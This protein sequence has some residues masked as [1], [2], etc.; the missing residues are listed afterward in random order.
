MLRSPILAQW[1]DE[2]NK[3]APTLRCFEYKVCLT[4]CS[5]EV[6]LTTPTQGVHTLGNLTNAKLIKSYDVVIC[7]FDVLGKEM[8]YAKKPSDRSMRS[9]RKG[10]GQRR[11]LLVEL[12]FLRVGQCRSTIFLQ[13]ADLARQ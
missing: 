9:G 8:P 13:V 2:I 6:D 10:H 5:A 4:T 11:S 3:H 1:M 12:D 7:S